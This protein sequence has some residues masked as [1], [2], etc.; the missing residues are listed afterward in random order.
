MLEFDYPNMRDA[1]KG[2]A[3]EMETYFKNCGI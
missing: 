3:K 2:P 1:V